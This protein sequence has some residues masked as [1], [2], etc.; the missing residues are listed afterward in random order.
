MMLLEDQGKGLLRDHRIPVPLGRT[1]TGPDQLGDVSVPAMVKALVPTGGRGKVG[2][3]V[4]ASNREEVEREARRVLRMI[5]HG[6]PVNAVLIEE[7]LAIS[8]EMY[9]SIL[10][11]RSLGTPAILVADR[12]GVDVE[13]LPKEAVHKWPVHPFLGIGAYRAREVAAALGLEGQNATVHDLLR[14]SVGAVRGRGL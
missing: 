4:L 3:V 1:I 8:K 12:G 10:I 13:S 9:L 5:I 2:G 11:D 7:V 6:H 14:P